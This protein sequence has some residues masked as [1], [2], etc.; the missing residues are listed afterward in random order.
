M[1]VN[2][3]NMTSVKKML[4]YCSDINVKSVVIPPHMNYT[5]TE[6][7]KICTPISLL[8][9]ATKNGSLE[10]VKFLHEKGAKIGDT[11]YHVPTEQKAIW[12]L[13]IYKRMGRHRS[14]DFK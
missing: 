10:M 12:L 8:E 4:N 13:D 14:S 2:K 9:I 7:N 1:L 3:N 5:K 6:I 11:K